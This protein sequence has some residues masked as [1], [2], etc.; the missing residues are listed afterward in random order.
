MRPA[1]PDWKEKQRPAA[2]SLDAECYFRRRRRFFLSPPS[3]SPFSPPGEEEFSSAEDSV[4]S[5]SG[6]ESFKQEYPPALLSRVA[7]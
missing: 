7:A 5:C 6:A 1:E 2:V 4:F 3:E